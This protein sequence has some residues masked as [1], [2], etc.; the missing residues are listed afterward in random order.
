MG[1]K[2]ITQTLAVLVLL[3]AMFASACGYGF[4]HQRSNLP[5]EIKTIA[6]PM[7]V[8]KTNE[9]RLEGLVTE[10]VRFQFSNSQILKLV[11]VEEADVI[12]RGE[13]TS[14]TYDDVTLTITTTSLS[15]RVGVGIAAKLLYRE[16]GEVLYNGGTSQWRNYIIN[17][18][19]NM[20]SDAARR[21]A[22]RL[23]AREAARIIHDGVLQN[24]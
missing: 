2:R 9:V 6:I 20:S 13:I 10:Q 14:V 17:A 15:R 7:F 5:P 8:N 1:N 12:L 24:F 19:D 3:L 11:A 23:T 4:R 22:L 18:N 16:T 21:E